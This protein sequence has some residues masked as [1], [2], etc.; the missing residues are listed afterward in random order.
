MYEKAK[1]DTFLPALKS[2]N[3]CLLLGPEILCI[4]KPDNTSSSVLDVFSEYMG[5]RL[6]EE[7]ISYD[8]SINNFYYRAGRFISKKFPPPDLNQ[9]SDEIDVFVNNII[10]Q[11]T[12]YFSKLIRLPFH[13]IV[14][15]VPDHF[16]SSTLTKLGY[17]FVEEIYDYSNPAR[18]N[19]TLTDE[20]KLV[21]YLF[22]K[23]DKPESVAVTEKDQLLQIKNIVAGT[24]PIPDNITNRFKDQKK[25]FLFLGF[26]FNDWYFRLVIDALKIPK[27]K[28]SYYPLYSN[29]HQTAFLA[30]EYYT[31][32]YGI[33]FVDPST[34][35][36]IDEMILRYE[37]R[38]GPLGRKLSFV[39][40]FHDDDMAVFAELKTQLQVNLIRNRVEFWDK[41]TGMIGGGAV[42]SVDEMAV[43]ADIYVPFLSRFFLNDAACINRINTCVQQAHTSIIPIRAGFVFYEAVIPDLKKK[44][45]MILPQEDKEPL[46]GLAAP[47]LSKTC[48]ELASIINRIVH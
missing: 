37:T 40:D 3:C 6:V 33:E 43:K 10:N 7:D 1:W 2:G 16:V 20:M 27:P 14:N 17:E 12:D 38:Y 36:F 8:S 35:N 18:S 46:S 42:A 19:P 9:F 11:P 4:R 25:S 41:T 26:N 22:G 31:E 30:K 44:S 13:S 45:L 23:Y 24:P 28:Q 48:F 39:F 21:Y 32:K 29:A 15:M 47:M 34:E 5:K